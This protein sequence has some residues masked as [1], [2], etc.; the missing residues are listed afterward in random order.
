MNNSK[1]KM[2][3]KKSPSVLYRKINMKC[4][5]VIIQFRA[6]SATGNFFHTANT[7]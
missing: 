4:V 5:L 6:L 7:T 1:I 3:S 2:L